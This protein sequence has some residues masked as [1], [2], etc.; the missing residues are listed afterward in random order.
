MALEE[1]SEESRNTRKYSTPKGVQQGHEDLSEHG[2]LRFV[3]GG[4]GILQSDVLYVVPGVPILLAIVNYTWHA[5][6]DPSDPSN[7]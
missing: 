3:S 4:G 1:S 6:I 7:D 5:F 2:I